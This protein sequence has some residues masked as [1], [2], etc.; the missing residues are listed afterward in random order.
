VQ[1]AFLFE[2]GEGGVGV[3]ENCLSAEGISEWILALEQKEV[4]VFVRL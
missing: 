2:G 3:N 1:G 4:L